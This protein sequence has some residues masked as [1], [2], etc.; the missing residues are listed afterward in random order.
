MVFL[1]LHIPKAI[2]DALEPTDPPTECPF[3]FGARRSRATAMRV[4]Q[5]YR[6]APRTEPTGMPPNSST[7]PSLTSAPSQSEIPARTSVVSRAH[8]LPAVLS[9]LRLGYD[10]G[11]SALGS[12]RGTHSFSSLGCVFPRLPPPSFDT[13]N[14]LTTPPILL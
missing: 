10:A 5:A 6:H 9:L 2:L 14:L 7:D 4:G 1:P 8:R 3:F 13:P 11:T 12:A